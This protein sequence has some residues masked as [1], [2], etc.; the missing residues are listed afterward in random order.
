M[1]A[2]NRTETARRCTAAGDTVVGV[3]VRAGFFPTPGPLLPPCFLPGMLFPQS[4][5]RP[6]CD[7]IRQVSLACPVSEG[8]PGL[9]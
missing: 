7:L 4:R 5:T 8:F 2:Q 6:S 3:A 9:V 1:V